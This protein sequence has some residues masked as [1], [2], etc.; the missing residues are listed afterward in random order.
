MTKET[1][2]IEQ[3]TDDLKKANAVITTR[4]RYPC[5]LEDEEGAKELKEGRA[6]FFFSSPDGQ[7]YELYA[8]LR[9]LGYS[10]GGY[11]APYHWR[12]SKSGGTI[13]YTEGDIY[14]KANQ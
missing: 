5:G 3:L 4:H 2:S 7:N 13:S 6:H 12:I 10:E 8:E 11:N 14:L 9:K 1:I